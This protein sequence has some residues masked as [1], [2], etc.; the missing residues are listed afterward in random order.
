MTVTVYL[1]GALAEKF[2]PRHELE[3]NTPREAIR[4]FDANYPTFLNEF[5]KYPEYILV[6]DNEHRGDDAVEFPVFRE[7]H[8]APQIEGQAFLGAALITAL[9]PGVTA[10]MATILGGLLVAGVLIGLS[11]LLR[12]KKKEKEEKEEAKDDS[13]AFSGPDNVTEQGVAVPLIYGR[14]YTG[15]VVISA[16]LSVSD[17]AIT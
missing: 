16:G 7:L 2:G 17:V 10:T 8:I 14:V 6:A 11:L 1:H 13:Y 9:I 15:S 5:K 4:A 3:I 12:P